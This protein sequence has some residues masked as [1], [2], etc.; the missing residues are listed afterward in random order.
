MVT[1]DSVCDYDNAGAIKFPAP[2]LPIRPQSNLYGLID[3]RVRKRLMTTLI[4]SP[5]SE[6]TEPLAERLLEIQAESIFDRR[7]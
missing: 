5:A 2:S 1:R 4:P 6:N 3:L 7:L